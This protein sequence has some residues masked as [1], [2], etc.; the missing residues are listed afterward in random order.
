MQFTIAKM[1]P[2]KATLDTNKNIF[3]LWRQN[4]QLIIQ[5]VRVV[6]EHS[7]YCP[8]PQRLLYLA[9]NTPTSLIISLVYTEKL[10]SSTR[11]NQIVYT[12]RRAS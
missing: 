3:S 6:Q 11:L 2:H 9:S 1:T 10:S 4:K 12:V 7:L 8:V 5:I